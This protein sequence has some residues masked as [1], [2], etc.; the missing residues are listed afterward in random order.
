M[1]LTNGCL[2][3]G[4][5]QT[6]PPYGM[7][8]VRWRIIVAAKRRLC[9]LYTDHWGWGAPKSGIP[10]LCIHDDCKT[11]VGLLRDVFQAIGEDP[12]AAR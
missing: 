5:Q 2:H 3:D 8:A 1:Q 11:L 4:P 12:H 6:L 7:S 9:T 10:V